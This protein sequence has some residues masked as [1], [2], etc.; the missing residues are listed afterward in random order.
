[1]RYTQEDN[2]RATRQY[3]AEVLGALVS[4]ILEMIG[5]SANVKTFNLTK[6]GGLE[7]FQKGSHRNRYSRRIKANKNVRSK[8]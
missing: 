7:D 1:M 4:K 3:G 2:A 8:T 6:Q 5:G